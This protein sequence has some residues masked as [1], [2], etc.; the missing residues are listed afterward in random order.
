MPRST[1]GAISSAYCENEALAQRLVCFLAGVHDIGKATP[2]FQARRVLFDTE[3]EEAYLTW[4][5]QSAGLPFTS[6]FD[7][8]TRPSHAIAGQVILKAYL[9]DEHHWEAGIAGSLTCIIGAHHGRPPRQK[10]LGDAVRT[11]QRELGWD[12]SCGSAWRDVQ[13]ELIEHALRLSEITRAD[14]TLM[15]GRFVEPQIASLL[16]GLIIMVDWIVSNQAFFPLVPLHH[17]DQPSTVALCARHAAQQLSARSAKAWDAARILPAWREDACDLPDMETLYGER[18]G[19]TGGTRPRP[20]Q[21][22]SDQVARTTEDPGIIILEA[23]MGEG[24]TEAALAAAEILASRSGCGGIAVALPTMATTDAMFGRVHAWLKRL[25]EH[26]E[27]ERSIYLAHGKARLNEEF[28]GIVTASR[29]KQ[30]YK[31]LGEDLE[32]GELSD[33]VVASD[34]MNGRKKGVLSNFLICTVDQVLMGALQMKHLAL[35]HLALANKVVVIDECHAYD[36][37]MQQYLTRVLEW[38]GS[39]RTPVVLLSATLPPALR[40]QLIE[41]YLKGRRTVGQPHRATGNWRET[42]R[43]AQ[44]WRRAELVSSAPASIASSKESGKEPSDVAA[45]YPLITY[46]EGEKMRSRGIPASSRRWNVTVKIMSDDNDSLIELLRERLSGGGCAGIVCDTV[47]RAQ[48]TAAALSDQ[49]GSESIMLT[50]ARFVDFDR[51]ANERM[52]RA[53]LGPEANVDAGTRPYLKI[54]VGTQVLEQSLDIDFDVLVSDVAPIDLIMQRLGRV[55]RHRR[56]TAESERPGKLRGATC[57]LRGIEH[58]GEGEAPSF[59][60]DVERV[61]DRASLLESLAVL[62]LSEHHPES[63]FELPDDVARTVR[64]GYGSDVSSRIPE[65]WKGIYADAVRK[66]SDVHDKKKRRARPCLL[67][68][69]DFLHSNDATLVDLF[70]SGAVSESNARRGADDDWGPRA[71]R[72][73]QE[74]VEVLLLWRQHDELRLLPW[75]GDPKRA[76]EYGAAVPMDQEPSPALSQFIMQSAVRLP[77]SMCAIGKIDSL[78]EKLETLTQSWIGAWQDSPWLAGSLVLILEERGGTELVVDIDNWEVS[79]S[80]EAGLSENVKRSENHLSS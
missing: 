47:T 14:L 4:K 62:E 73:T 32:A 27:N 70:A 71:V 35:R 28:Q 68:S 77:L 52:L 6:V 44:S 76:V 2:L 63:E 12:A 1:R 26:N 5:P 53:M 51:M 7:C 54:I 60:Q 19:F 15:S 64:A 23:P 72:D 49:F 58:W 24:K 34:W 36:I 17:S 20:I 46:S 21:I 56:G 45:A 11:R 40:A 55:H 13:R 30:R 39:W 79:Y 65:A 57:Y 3:A 59:P 42:A 50:H 37:Y 41:A 31:V 43:R 9:E 16:T 48:Q 38:L 74:T 61:Y 29:S 33:S 10:D 18:F 25:P 66:R 22:A 67:K 69:V 80:R 78:I 8:A 75:V